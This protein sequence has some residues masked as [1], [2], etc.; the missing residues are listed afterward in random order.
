MSEEG[1][2]V[3]AAS[4]DSDIM[5]LEVPKM[6][7][8]ESPEEPPPVGEEAHVSEDFHMGSS[9]SSQYTFC[10][11]ETGTWPLASSRARDDQG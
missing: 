1:S 11:P 9:F 10:Q 4:D 6:D 7:E 3:G 8:T 5:T 2:C